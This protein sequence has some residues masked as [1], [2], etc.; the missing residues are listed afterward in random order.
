[1]RDGCGV[2]CGGTARPGEGAAL[3]WEPR[4]VGCRRPTAVR[5][6]G[7]ALRC[8]RP[9]G[10]GGGGAASPQRARSCAAHTH[11]APGADRAASPVRRHP[12]P[13]HRRVSAVAPPCQRR[14][15]ARTAAPPRPAAPQRPPPPF[16]Q[17]RSIP[18]GRSEPSRYPPTGPCR[19]SPASAR[20]CPPFPS[21]PFPSRPVP[22]RPAH[23]SGRPRRSP[24]PAALWGPGRHRAGTA[25]APPPLPRCGVGPR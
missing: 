1:M 11:T 8:R 23:R 7:A 16:P 20:R 21:L 17:G 4:P 6:Y 13:Y 3:F 24:L 18:E 9:P 14:S 22:S 2:G 5:G 10:G 25:H 12:E 19:P 15:A